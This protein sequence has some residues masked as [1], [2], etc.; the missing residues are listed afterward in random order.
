MDCCGL[1]AD[2]DREVWLADQI[3]PKIG[4]SDDDLL[5]YQSDDGLPMPPAAQRHRQTPPS[6]PR[7]SNS[8]L[9][10]PAPSPSHTYHQDYQ[11]QSSLRPSPSSAARPPYHSTS[12]NHYSS[13]YIRR[14]SSRRRGGAPQHDN[15]G[16][17]SFSPSPVIE[18]K[19]SI[20]SSSSRA[21]GESPGATGVVKQPTITRGKSSLMKRQSTGISK[22]QQRD[23][24][25]SD[26]EEE[27][28]A[29]AK[30]SEKSGGG[31]AGGGVNG[32]VPTKL[33]ELTPE[34]KEEEKKR[35]QALV[36][37][38]AKEAV[39][40]FPITLI[41][42]NSG[43]E[44]SATFLMDRFLT[45]ITLQRE[46]D[47]HSSTSALEDITGIFK[48]DEAALHAPVAAA[49]QPDHTRLLG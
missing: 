21:Y 24:T 35:L 6:M 27:E 14:D 23:H 46:G 34:E 39:T 22:G 47:D 40:G 2:E 4:L 29:K 15:Y 11:H 28:P 1:C 48:G 42:E 16:D 30:S 33:S 41:D 38:F 31:P 10:K 19:P 44:T 13:D 45:T 5:D 36:K 8:S 17:D 7:R 37:D 18:K 20:H 25:P 49:T 9:R 12:T 3:S 43:R 32:K 26:K